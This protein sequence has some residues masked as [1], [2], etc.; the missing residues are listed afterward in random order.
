MDLEEVSPMGEM[1]S[2]SNESEACMFGDDTCDDCRRMSSP[3]N[4]LPEKVPC[5]GTGKPRLST[6]APTYEMTETS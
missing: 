1:A 2:S 5:E 6:F 4:I 3:F